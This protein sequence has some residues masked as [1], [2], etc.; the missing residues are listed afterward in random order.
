ML[1]GSSWDQVKV[2][3]SGADQGN[4]T[5]VITPAQAT[6]T[7]DGKKSSE[8]LPEGAWTALTTGVAALGART[9]KACEGQMLEIKA[10]SG[11]EV[12]QTFQASSCDGGEALEQ[13]KS[14]L[15]QLIA[16]LH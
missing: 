3:F 8:D 2:A 4:Y 7:I 1:G 10:L 16:Q 13:A 15:D 14:L 6:Y 11:G 12:K 5:L 9:S